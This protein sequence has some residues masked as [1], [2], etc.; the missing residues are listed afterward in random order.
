MRILIGFSTKTGH[1]RNLAGHVAAMLSDE[2]HQI[3]VVDLAKAVL[4]DPDQ[5]DAVILAGSLH[6]GRCPPS[7]QAFAH[8][9]HATLNRMP[10][11]FISVSLAATGDVPEDVAGLK[12]C[13]TRLISETGWCPTALHHAA[14]ALL[15][16][17]YGWIKQR[18]MQIIARRKGRE[19]TLGEDYD[20]TDYPA[21]ER[22]VEDF[23][24][25]SETAAE[26]ATWRP[27]LAS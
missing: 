20:Y 3:T 16:S 15:F 24:G 17:R 12:E 13:A 6:Y 7:L 18:V 8:R 5:D 14:G 19:V 21:L 27:A 1:T 25:D 2:G 10:T 26:A 4:P 9:H 23:I 11:A 22:F